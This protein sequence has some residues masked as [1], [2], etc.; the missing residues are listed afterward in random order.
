M[1]AQSDGGQRRAQGLG[2]A[3]VLASIC[4]LAVP[5]AMATV[6]QLLLRP[7]EEAF[8]AERF[9]AE[10][11]AYRDTVPCWVPARPHAH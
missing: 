2:V 4:A 5:V 8:L 6:W 11:E 10:F 3:L 9:G 7:R 1:G